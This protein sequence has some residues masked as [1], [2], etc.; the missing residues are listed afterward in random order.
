MH[1]AVDYTIQHTNTT[2]NKLHTRALN[3]IDAKKQENLHTTEPERES[4][5]MLEY[6]VTEKND[7]AFLE[8]NESP[9]YELRE[10]KPENDVP[11]LYGAI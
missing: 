6:I 4:R 8:Y 3:N 5:L 1:Q 10:I 7:A 9:N 2:D 11:I